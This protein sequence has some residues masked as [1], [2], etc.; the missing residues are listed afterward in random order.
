MALA[1]RQDRPQE[2]RGAFDDAPARDRRQGDEGQPLAISA[3]EARFG[4]AA[5]DENL[6]GQREDEREE[7]AVENGE[8]RVDGIEELAQ[9]RDWATPA[10]RPI[11]DVRV[12]GLPV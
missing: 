2:I 11:P 4:A 12:R 1:P 7:N 6:V 8:Q 3:R 9:R 5:I 10:G